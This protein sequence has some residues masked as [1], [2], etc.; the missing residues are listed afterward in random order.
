MAGPGVSEILAANFSYE[1]EGDSRKD[2]DGR[3][4]H[5]E[6]PQHRFVD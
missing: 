6:T 2:D 5:G 4:F 3:E 1:P